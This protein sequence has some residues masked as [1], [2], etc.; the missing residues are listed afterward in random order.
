MRSIRPKTLALPLFLCIGSLAAEPSLKDTYKDKFLIGAALNP[1]YYANETSPR[2]QLV[3][4][5]FSSITPENV[6]KWEPIHPKPGQYRFEAADRFLDFGVKNGMFVVGHTL[7][8]HQQTPKWVFEDEKGAPLT[9]DGLLERMREHIHTLVGRYK[10]RIKGWDVVNEALNENGTLRDS[11][12]KKI[13][14][15]D[16]VQKA[17]EY[18]HEADPTAELYYNDYRLEVPAKRDGAVALVKKIKA[19]GVP[20]TGIGI[21]EHVTPVWPAS[22]DLEAS[23]TAFGQLGLKVMI[24]ELDVDMLPGSK[25]F[26]DADISRRE[27]ADPAFNPYPKELPPEEQQKLARR[28]AELFGIYL[29][30]RGTITRVTLWG[31]NDGESWLNNF[32]I[33]GRVNHPLLFDRALHPKP[34]FGAVIDAASR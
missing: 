1:S 17:F 27:A 31:I 33:P 28:Y 7:V 15:D 8:W 19:A 18:A 12:W 21:Q 34:A 23:I 32:P 13:I 26:G 25:K 16:F 4:T 3:K 2:S 11:P 14:G 24:T 22:N 30:H 10:G 5:Q 29:K 6:M 20:V 9:R